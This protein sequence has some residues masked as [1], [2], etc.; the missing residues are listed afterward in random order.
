MD[1]PSADFSRSLVG[2]HIE[3]NYRG[4]QFPSEEEAAQRLGVEEA[5]IAKEKNKLDAL[6]ALTF[7]LDISEINKH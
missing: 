4:G 5:K 2:I 7:V 6:N 3:A 1:L